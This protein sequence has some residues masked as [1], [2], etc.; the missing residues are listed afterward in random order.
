VAFP[1]LPFRAAEQLHEPIA[2]LDRANGWAGLILVARA[3][4]FASGNASYSNLW[5]FRAPHWPVTIPDSRRCAS[6]RRP[7]WNDRRSR[8]AR[9]GDGRERFEWLG[10]NKGRQHQGNREFR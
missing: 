6:E 3:V 4:H 1:P 2:S 10:R 9:V 8:S 5:T 7:G